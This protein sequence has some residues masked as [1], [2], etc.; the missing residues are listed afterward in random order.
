MLY[1]LRFSFLIASLCWAQVATPSTPKSFNTNENIPISNIILPSFD[2]EQFLAEDENEL[3]S[4]DTKPYRFANPISVDLNM[5]NSG[6]WTELEDGSLIWMLEIESTNAFSLNLIYDTFNIPEGAEFFVYSKDREMV[7]GAFSNFNHKPHGGFSTAPV[8]G[9]KIILEYNEPANAEFAGYI[10][11]NTV[12]HDYRNV[13]FNT[14]RG[15]GDSG[16]CNNNVACSVGDDWV[17]EVRSVAMILTSGGS[18][19]C[20]GSLI[21]NATQDLSPYF[22]TA[23]HCLGG[24]NS[25]IFMFNY[26]SPQCT[27]QNGPT[28]MTVSGS[29]LLASS[30]TSDV[31]LLLLNETPPEDY[32]VHYAG[33]DVSGST[34]STPVGIHHPSGD[35]KKISFDYNNASNSGNYWDVDSWDD[36]TTE[37]GSSG[38]PLFDGVTHRIIGQ[39]YGG[40]ASCTNFGYDTYGKTSVSWNLG[41]SDYLDP[42]NT[43][44]SYIDGIDA[45]DLPDP[46]ISLSNIDLDFELES[47]DSDFS[48]ITISNT[49]ESESVLFYSLNIGSF[50]TPLGGPDSIDNFWSDSNNEQMLESEWIDITNVGNIYE[51]SNNDQSGNLIDIGFDFPFYGQARNQ[52]FINPNGW[53]GFGDDSNAWD[54]TSIPSSSAPRSSIFGFWDDLNPVNDDCNSCSGQVFYHSDGERMVIWFNNVAH[55]PTNFENSYYNFQIVI[56]KSGDIKF[57]YDNMVGIS[58]SATIGIQND[59]GT[60]GLQMSYNTEYVENNLT[61]HIKKNPIWA[62]INQLNNFE[63]SGELVAGNSTTLDIII[64]NIEL[65]EG[66]YNASLNISSNAS[67]AIS[68]PITLTSTSD[69]ILGDLN[70]DAVINVVDIVQLVNIALGLSPEITAADVNEDG[71]INVLDVIQLVNIVLDN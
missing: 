11:I 18:R 3:R 20:T 14:E 58:N 50:E 22:L 64:E 49:G 51:F 27:N 25:W 54:N 7:L 16:S 67:T 8:K 40:V 71:I 70:G 53:I 63:Y 4:T 28:N 62:G 47:N 61:T 68:Y 44:L 37:P 45:I 15:Y 17:D 32:N 38:S 23:N 60:S 13:F 41:L 42:N 9:D 24:N 29:T 34:P 48:S 57:N 43:G 46:A 52:L 30:S 31:A 26:E 39:L 59:S 1:Y 36:G 5:D 21:N 69:I 19:L 65:P 35:I 12:A 10:S 66:I 2:V 55:W 33:W 56:Y 6:S